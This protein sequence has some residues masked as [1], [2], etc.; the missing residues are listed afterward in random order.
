MTAQG[1]AAR[2]AARRLA[3]LKFAYKIALMPG[4]AALGFLTIVLVSGMVG[5]NNSQLLAGIEQSNFPA[6]A[7]SRDLEEALA[8]IQRGLQD[9]VAAH[10]KTMLGETD[11]LRGADRVAAAGAARGGMT[12]TGSRTMQHTDGAT[13]S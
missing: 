5:T 9:A 11:T 2:S 13:D 10:D 7:A 8:A 12:R 1:S 3:D 6:L 4:L